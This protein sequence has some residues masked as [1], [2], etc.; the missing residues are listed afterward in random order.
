[1]YADPC[2]YNNIAQRNKSVV[3]ELL[4]RLIQHQKQAKQIIFPERDIEADPVRRKGFWGPWKKLSNKD[5]LQK[6]KEGVPDPP[7]T[8]RRCFGNQTTKSWVTKSSDHLRLKSVFTKWDNIKQLSKSIKAKLS[9][10]RKFGNSI[11]RV[12]DS[13][14]IDSK[15]AKGGNTL[16]NVGPKKKEKAK[17][18]LPADSMKQTST[19]RFDIPFLDGKTDDFEDQKDGY[20]IK[21]HLDARSSVNPASGKSEDISANDSQDDG[22]SENIQNNWIHSSTKYRNL[23][24]RINEKETILEALNRYLNQTYEKKLR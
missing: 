9:K 23:N 11:R 19:K 1:M 18:I 13:I 3:T 14:E 21:V 6:A 20:H 24:N 12:N 7:S 15:T 16:A 22:S 5:I 10:L 2:E 4:I 17:L 8:H